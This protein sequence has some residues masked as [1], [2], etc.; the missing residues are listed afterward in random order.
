MDKFPT[1]CIK[2]SKC[3]H[4][5]SSCSFAVITS[6]VLLEVGRMALSFC[7]PTTALG[8]LSTS[9]VKLTS[10]HG[11]PEKSLKSS[12]NTYLEILG[13]TEFLYGNHEGKLGMTSYMD[14]WK[15]RASH[16][17]APHLVS[18][19]NNVPNQVVAQTPCVHNKNEPNLRVEQCDS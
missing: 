8:L 17:S 19:G 14:S 18:F 12:K 16:S 1:T 15:L 3:N 6:S 10:M 9:K 7:V 5:L 4:K 13:Y 2:Y 11:C